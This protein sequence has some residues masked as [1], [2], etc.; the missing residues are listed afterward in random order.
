MVIPVL[1]AQ[2]GRFYAAVFELGRRTS[3][4]LDLP[5]TELLR[6]ADAFPEVLFVGPA[7]DL[8]AGAEEGRQGLRIVRYGRGSSGRGLLDLAVARFG[9]D[10]PADPEAGPLY[11]RKSDAET[12]PGRAAAPS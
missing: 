1:D 6:Y 12:A 2:R 4:Y 7:A 11:V 3:D 5:L 10:G 8:L 9:T